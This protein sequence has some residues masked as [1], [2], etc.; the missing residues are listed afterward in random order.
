MKFFLNELPW[1]ARLDSGLDWS[2]E[3]RNVSGVIIGCG[4]FFSLIP[5]F[6]LDALFKLLIDRHNAALIS[7]IIALP[8]SIYV[9]KIVYRSLWLNYYE[10]AEANAKRRLKDKF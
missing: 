5:F 4:C 7:M 1:W 9:T 8:P 2:T 10:R 3:E 6:I